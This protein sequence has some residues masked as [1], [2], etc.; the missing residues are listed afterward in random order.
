MYAQLSSVKA[1]LTLAVLLLGYVAFSLANRGS[2]E[3]PTMASQALPIAPTPPQR[4]HICYTTT[5]SILCV[6]EQ[7]M[8]VTEK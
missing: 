6:D 1:G 4:L 5:A 3:K 7:V 8:S 2:R